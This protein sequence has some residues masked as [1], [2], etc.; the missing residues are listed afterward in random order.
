V[1]PRHFQITIALLLACIL[2]SGI[3]IIK[4]TH[5]E[6]AKNLLGSQEIPVAPP[7][8]GKSERIPM[9]IAY[10]EDR[11][12]RWREVAVFLPDERNQRAREVLR[13]LLAEYLQ[14]PSPHP[15]GKGSDI[16]DV[17]LVGTDTAIIDTSTQFA[18]GHPSGILQEELTIAS[19][20]ETLSANVPGI[21][22]VKFVVEGQERQTLAGH[23][24][25][26]SFYQTS[27]VHELAKEFE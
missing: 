16:R 27:A 3:Y 24:D 21:S 23:A 2:V 10:D 1:I 13:G 15:L 14:D 8:I 11:A 22:R 6:Q 12:L 9:L 20:I 5:K 26:M 4:L 7:R 19:L 25:L 18:A 17:Y